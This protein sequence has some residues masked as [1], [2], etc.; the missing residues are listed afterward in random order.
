MKE[1]VARERFRFLFVLGAVGAAL[2]A[3]L[4]PAQ[5][6]SYG[7]DD[8][9]LREIWA[10][11]SENSQVYELA[12]NLMDVIGPRVTGTPGLDRAHLWLEERYGEWGVEVEQQE[13]G[14]WQGWE[15]GLTRVDLL[16][17]RRS[18]LRA[19]TLAWSGGT[20]GPQEGR[21][22]ILPDASTPA[23]FREWLE[24]DV[25]GA[26]VL[27]S[28][29]QPTCRPDEY[30]ERHGTQ[31]SVQAMRDDRET[32]REEWQSRVAASTVN[33][34]FLPAFL[35]QAGAAGVLTS[36][37]AESWGTNRIF[38]SQTR[39]I[40][41]VDLECED[42]GLLARLAEHGHEPEIR[43]DVEAE[44]LGET[45]TY[46]TVGR[47]EGSERP[48]EY[49]LLSAHLDTWGGATGATDN[50]TGT[51]IMMEAMRIL[52]EVYPNPRRT[53]LAGHWGGE[54]QGLNGS[55]AFAEDNPHVLEGLQI[56]M[57]Q[58]NGTGRI[59]EIDMQGFLHAGSYF[60]RWLAA[61][62]DE[63]SGRIDLGIPG[64]PDDG[65][66][67]HASFVC[68]GMPA[69]RLGSHEWD[70]RDYTWHTTRDTFD[71][72]SFEEV[73]ENAILT[74]MLAYLASEEPELMPRDRR[75][76]PGVDGE[77][78]AWPTCRDPMRAMPF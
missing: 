62:P 39:D 57:N 37:W 76:L 45:P 69:F 23:E 71:K 50:G 54:E 51:V 42:Y 29:P 34:Q 77:G 48:D 65:R 43:I 55:A 63:L 6:Q 4:S 36:T 66:S 10:E 60:G 49:V 18:S 22:V 9:V 70:Y 19:H 46:N 40:P 61:V 44:F 11:G 30:W 16:E 52:R 78:M 27:A 64:L 8:P 41:S 35:E 47:I 1:R 28:F 14:T 3:P 21:V 75:D 73:R 25:P 38:L 72:I 13:Y 31:A 26:F 7:T 67:D 15:S 5:A 12:R 20:E 74:A 32:S 33:P 2:L 24:S 59:T 53:I 17:P 58:D 56:L 68:H